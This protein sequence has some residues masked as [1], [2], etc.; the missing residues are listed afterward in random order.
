[1]QFPAV[2]SLVIA[3][4]F[5]S[6]LAASAPTDITATSLMSGHARTL[7]DEPTCPSHTC[8]DTSDCGTGCL[9]DS[10]YYLCFSIDTP[11]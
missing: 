11:W 4:A 6:T 5:F 8:Q 9:C 7:L 2:A 1:M 3:V 10:T